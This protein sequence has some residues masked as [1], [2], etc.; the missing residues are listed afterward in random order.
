MDAPPLISSQPT[1]H[2]PAPTTAAYVNDYYY[3]RNFIWPAL[4][5]LGATQML[6]KG[7]KFS[8]KLITL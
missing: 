2:R 6:V 1:D 7:K 3:S 4:R 5:Q 8:L